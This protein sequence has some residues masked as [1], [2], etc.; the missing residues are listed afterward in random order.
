VRG[1]TLHFE[2]RLGENSYMAARNPELWLEPLKDEAG[3][4][5]GALAGRILDAEGKPAKVGNILLERLGGKGQPAVEQI[6]LKTYADNRLAGLT[7]WEE[8]F[9]AGDLV[10][11]SYQISFWA[12]GLHQKVVEVLPGLL[13]TVTIQMK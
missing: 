11:G 4:S 9:A 6:Y 2:V 7:P 12:R 5:L 3:Q 13:V 10:P 8:N 1:S